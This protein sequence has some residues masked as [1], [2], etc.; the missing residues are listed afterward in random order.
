M[1]EKENGQ[2]K[3]VVRKKAP[4]IV[5]N[6]PAKRSSIDELYRDNPGKDFAYA[7]AQTGQSALSN[8][9]LA[10]VVGKDGNA[11]MVGNKLIC[12]VVGDQGAKETAEQFKIASEAAE[13]VRDK[14]RSS[15]D[16]KAVPKKPIK[17][18]NK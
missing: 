14:K 15:R 18:D 6:S 9:G 13:T 17:K 8:Q 11:L 5:V 12:E 10:P 2:E 16:K 1:N 7:P 4:A 3:T